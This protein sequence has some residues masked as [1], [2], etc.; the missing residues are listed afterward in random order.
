[1]PQIADLSVRLRRVTHH[2]DFATQM[3]SRWKLA[4]VL[5]ENYIVGLFHQRRIRLVVRVNEKV[6]IGFEKT[7]MGIIPKLSENT[8]PPDSQKPII[9]IHRGIHAFLEDLIDCLGEDVRLLHAIPE[10]LVKPL[11]AFMDAPHK[12]DVKALEHVAS[13]NILASGNML[14]LLDFWEKGKR[15]LE[16]KTPSSSVP[17]NSIPALQSP[18]RALRHNKSRAFD[19]FRDRVRNRFPRFTRQILSPIYDLFLKIFPRKR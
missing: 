2:G 8:V 15:A 5:P 16:N 9:A 17:P 7:Q 14:Y 13:E 10:H 12:I 19:S 3:Q 6:R 11:V 4:N 1:M 18:R